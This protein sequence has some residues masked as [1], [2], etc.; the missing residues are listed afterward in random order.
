MIF[1]SWEPKVVISRAYLNPDIKLS[2]DD[3]KVSTAYLQK[4]DIYFERIVPYVLFKVLSTTFSHFSGNMR[5]S[6]RKN[7]SSVETMQESTHFSV[8][9]YDVKGS[10]VRTVS[11]IGTNDNQKGNAARLHN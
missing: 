11:S 5:I 10:S 7:C 3:S 8:S 9:S 4:L 2:S 1:M 6:R